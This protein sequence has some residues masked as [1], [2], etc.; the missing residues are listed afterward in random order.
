MHLLRSSHRAA[1]RAVTLAGV[2]AAA[3][4]FS[5]AHAETPAPAVP[6]SKLADTPVGENEEL[7]ATIDVRQGKEA[8]GAITVRLHHKY[9]PAHVKNFV[10]LAETSFYDGTKFHRVSPESFVQ[11][12]DP[13]SRD[14]DPAN[15]GSG[16]PGF[17][18]P[19]E[20]NEKSFTRGAVGAA[21]MGARD[22]GSQFFICLKDHTEWDKNYTAIGHVIGGLEIADRMSKADRKGEHP[23]D[24]FV[25]T[26]KVEKR[27]KQAKLY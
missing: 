12:G 11:G 6:A 21:R 16:G 8:L 15:D 20:L 26:V 2:L 18:Q 4:L 1:A 22:N 27:K 23:V 17:D 19:L 3:A 14:A 5:V 7:V 13:L 24:D 25:M 10:Q 9:A